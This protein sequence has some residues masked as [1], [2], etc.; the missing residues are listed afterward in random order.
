MRKFS[1]QLAAAVILSLF[2][3]PLLTHAEHHEAK[4]VQD[5]E[6]GNAHVLIV[7]NKDNPDFVILDVRTEEEYSQGHLKDSFNIDYKSDTFVEEVG[8]LDKTKTYLVYCRT[9]RRSDEAAKKMVEADFVD[10]YHL[11][12][13][14][15][16]W[17]ES[18]F[19]VEK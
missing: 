15:T 7:K 8:R 2:T 11:D 17:Q 5:I 1:L 3:Y 19:P 10:I 6:P 18:G 4:A 13:G 16:E 9:G 14:I 12:G